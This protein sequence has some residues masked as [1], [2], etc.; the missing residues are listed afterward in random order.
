[1][2]QDKIINET[3]SYGISLIGIPYQK[4]GGNE[5][6]QGP[7]MFAI[8]NPLPSLKEITTCNCAGLVN[9]ILRYR[10]KQLPFDGITIGGTKAYFSYYLDK[11][12]NFDI[13]TNYPK[14]TLLLK[15]YVDINEQGHVAIIIEN[16]GRKSKILQSQI[17]NY[18][19][20][21]NTHYTLEQSHD[22][23]NYEKIVLPDNWLF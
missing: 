5:I 20:G 18:I 14:G 23:Y 17:D 6:E 19:N 1:M 16:K 4:W 7:P 15:N 9:L 3:I 8:N 13:N 2:N 22:N 11:S 12:E 10:N 21:I